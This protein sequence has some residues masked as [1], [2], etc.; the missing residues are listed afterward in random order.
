MDICP[1]ELWNGLEHRLWLQVD[2]VHPFM[3]VGPWVSPRS[4]PTCLSWIRVKIDPTL[5]VRIQWGDGWRF[6]AQF[7]EEWTL[8][9]SCLLKYLHEQLFCNDSKST[10][11]H[12]SGIQNWFC[13]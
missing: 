5:L 12:K 13:R 11:E 9:K 2:V 6:L 3:G 4:V 1:A 7:L 10:T 8:K